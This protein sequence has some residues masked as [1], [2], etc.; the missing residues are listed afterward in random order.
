MAILPLQLARVSN[1]LRASVSQNQLS[2]TQEALLQIQNQLSTGKRLNAPSDDPGDSA[3]VQQLRKTLEKRESYA[4]NLRHASSQLSEVD[5][6]LSD[7]TRL[8]EQAQS[9]ASANVGSDVTP[10]SRA[11]AA[12]VVKSIYNQVLTLS[13]KQSEGS[14]L[15]G[16]DRATETPFR[17]AIGGVQ[18]VGSSST[19]A[20]RHDENSMAAFQISGA[21]VFNALSTRVE[22]TGNLTPAATADT[23]LTDLRGATGNG[24]QIGSIRI[25]NGTDT[26][27]VELA[28]ADTLGDVAD[29]INAAGLSGVSAS[30][31]GNGLTLTPAGVEQISVTDLNGGT[32]ATDLGIVQTTPLVAGA[33]LTGANIAPRVTGLTALSDLLGGTGLDVSSGITITNGQTTRSID[34]SG[35][36]TVE[37]FLNQI[38][39]ANVGVTASVNAGGTGINIFNNTEGTK[40]SISENGGTLAATLGVRT[41][42]ESSPLTELN[43]GLGVRTV[44]GADLRITRKDGSTFAVDLSNLDTI[45]DV[46]DAINTADAGAGVTASFG[47]NGNGIVLTDTTGGPGTLSVVAENASNAAADLGLTTAEVAGVITGTDVNPIEATGLFANL[48]KLISS[49]ELSNQGGITAAGENLQGDYDRVVRIRGEAGARVQEIESRENRL[50]DQNIAT[51]TLLSSLED[52]DMT[53]AIVKFQTLQTALEAVLRMTGRTLNTSLLDYL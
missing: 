39:G 28:G 26:V 44:E 19:L 37:D 33:T 13:N 36:A 25:N 49:L 27:L 21:D 45:Q 17:E 48:S 47:A 8:V 18:F 9:I 43:G 10:D 34:F 42:S 41:F 11:T 32:T 12:V 20:N 1:T 3:I 53:D 2:R 51:K 22:G 31:T 35:A 50:A 15:F 24:V 7:L 30:I 16:G 4:D 52:V 40:M 29:R 23:R 5:Q 14:Y 46:L 6:T 38:N